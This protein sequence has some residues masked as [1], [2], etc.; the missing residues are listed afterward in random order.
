MS[1]DYPRVLLHIEDG[2]RQVVDPEKV[3]FLEAVADSTRVHLGPAEILSDVRPLRDLLPRFEPFGFL[4]TH[5]SY[6]LNPVR[7]HQL[8]RR[9]RGRDWEVKLEAPVERVLPVSRDLYP[10]LLRLLEG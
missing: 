6:A 7:V 9:Q 1:A 2:L 5:R 4:R 10:R 8:R 3:Y